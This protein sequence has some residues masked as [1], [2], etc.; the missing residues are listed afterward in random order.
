MYWTVY[1]IYFNLQ[2]AVSFLHISCWLKIFSNFFKNWAES[3]SDLFWSP[4]VRRLSVNFSH[5][6]PLFLI[7]WYNHMALHKCV[8]WLELTVFLGERCSPWSSC[9]LFIFLSR[10]DPGQ[11]RSSVSLACRKR[12][13][14][15]AVLRMRPCKPMSRV[16][17]GMAR[18]YMPFLLFDIYVFNS[19]SPNP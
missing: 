9:L 8:N 7:I 12:R 6:Q 18:F 19:P 2:R 5:F 15:R 13:L 1:R 3:S 14:N 17:V 11:N 10:G 16:K 4:V